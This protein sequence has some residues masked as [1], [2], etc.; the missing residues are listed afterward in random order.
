M[1]KTFCRMGMVIG[2][3]LLFVGLFAQLTDLHV[4]IGGLV[5]LMLARFHDRE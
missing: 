1:M 3:F 2:P 5:W 4:M